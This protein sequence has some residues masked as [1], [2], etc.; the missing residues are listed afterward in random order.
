MKRK[1]YY[2]RH[3]IL[4]ICN[5]LWNNCLWQEYIAKVKYRINTNLRQDLN[6]L[7]K[8]IRIEY[9]RLKSLGP[10][11]TRKSHLHNRIKEFFDF[12]PYNL[13][14]NFLKNLHNL[15]IFAN[16]LDNI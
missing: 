7:D 11:V 3:S 6:I 5:H 9:K 14:C 2:R 13:L 15:Y 16:I 12:F 1:D 10:R 4:I 8:D